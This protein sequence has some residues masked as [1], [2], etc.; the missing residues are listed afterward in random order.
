MS[1]I[2][3]S[4]ELHLLITELIMHVNILFPQIILNYVQLKCYAQIC[5]T[6]CC[7]WLVY[8]LH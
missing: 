3:M 7:V 5:Y 8:T 4:E 2:K 1:W 6:K